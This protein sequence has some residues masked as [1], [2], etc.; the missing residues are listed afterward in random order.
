MKEKVSLFSNNFFIKKTKKQKIFTVILVILF[1]FIVIPFAFYNVFKMASDITHQYSNDFKTVR[2]YTSNEEEAHQYYEKISALDLKNIIKID[3]PVKSSISAYLGK[4]KDNF[5]LHRG[6]EGYIPKLTSGREIQNDYEIICPEKAFMGVFD[7]IKSSE[8]IDMKSKLNEDFSFK[9]YKDNDF[10]NA[11]LK[12]ESFNLVGTYNADFSYSYNVCYISEKLFDSFYN[13]IIEDKENSSM[14]IYANDNESAQ[15][16]KQELNDLGI[17]A[18]VPV[19]VD[20]F[21]PTILFV[22][23]M[24]L[25][26]SIVFV[27]MFLIFHISNYIKEENNNIALYRICGMNDAQVLNVIYGEYFAI[28]TKALLYAFV[29]IVFLRFIINSYL[30]SFIFFRAVNINISFY[31]LIILYLVILIIGYILFKMDSKKLY[32]LEIREIKEK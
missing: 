14:I 4:E 18:F 20:D 2:I 8:L 28:V 30:K 15:K 29:I 6:F 13:D 19:L 3:Y 27:S 24:L 1:T 32:Q 31:P 25:L 7:D 22:S 23:L 17:A 21:V 9:F 10:T 12:E 5:K 26:I 16:I 11:L